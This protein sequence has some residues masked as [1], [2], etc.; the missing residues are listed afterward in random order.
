MKR[1][2]LVLGVVFVAVGTVSTQDA[3]KLDYGMYSKIRDEGLHRSQAMDHVSWLADVY[4]RRLIGTIGVIGGTIFMV[5]MYLT[6]GWSIWLF[7]ALAGLA[8]CWH[9]SAS[10]A[11]WHTVSAAG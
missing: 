1:F 11:C 5:A 10:T 8:S 7:A 2:A 9:P 4:G 3:G 6:S